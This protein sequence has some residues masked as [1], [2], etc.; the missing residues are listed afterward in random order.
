MACNSASA[1]VQ[2]A[3]TWDYSEEVELA[4]PAKGDSPSDPLRIERDTESFS[5]EGEH[6]SLTVDIPVASGSLASL[7]GDMPIRSLFFLD[8]AVL[9][10]WIPEELLK[11]PIAPAT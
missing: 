1:G 4:E 2:T 11:I 3:L 9:P 5:L 7:S 8:D 6:T 10:D